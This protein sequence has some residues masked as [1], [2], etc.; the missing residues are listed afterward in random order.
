MFYE[1]ER[2]VRKQQKYEKTRAYAIVNDLQRKGLS[3][4]EMIEAVN[5]LLMSENTECQ[6]AILEKAKLI[7]S[8]QKEIMDEESTNRSDN[9]DDDNSVDCP[10][11]HYREQLL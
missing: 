2:I 6:Q 8:A 4:Q 10:I 1:S 5:I 11:I 7:L 9:G 3:H